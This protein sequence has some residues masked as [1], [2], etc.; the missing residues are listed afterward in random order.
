VTETDRARER[1]DD[2]AFENDRVAHRMYGPALETWKA[3]PLTSSGIDVW[4]KRTPRLVVNE[5][6][7]SDDYH[8]DNGDGA[9]FYS[10]G[11][12]RGCGRNP[13]FATLL[14]VRWREADRKRIWRSSPSPKLRR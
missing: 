14:E 2:F 1:H 4:V 5:W 12:S 3:D 7:Q 8:R 10:V 13:R 9:D 11:P 6:Y